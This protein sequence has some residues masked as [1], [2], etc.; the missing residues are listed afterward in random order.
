METKIPITIKKLFLLSLL[1]SIAWPGFFSKVSMTMNDLLLVQ[2][3]IDASCVFFSA[4][5]VIIIINDF[6]TSSV[7][8]LQ[9]NLRPWP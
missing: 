9:G 7:H 4:K 2:A 1:L 5:K 3:D 8:P 6:L